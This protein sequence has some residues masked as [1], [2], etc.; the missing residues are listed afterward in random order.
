MTGR[1]VMTAGDVVAVLNALD[2]YQVEVSVAGGWAVDA[3]LGEQTREHAD[4]D[5]WAPATHLEWLLRALANRGLD[6]VFPCPGD[7]PWNFV[8][9]DGDRRRVDLHLYERLP[10]GRLHYGSAVDGTVFEAGALGGCGEIAG[11]RVRCEAP[12]WAVRWHT[13]YPP[14]AADRHDVP[15]LCAR[16][17]IPLPA[18]FS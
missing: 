11:R 8:L 3:L 18:D 14:R 10:D 7:R 1:Y 12:E 16:F 15:L 5:L 13:G 9:H 2:D 6:R 4:L 17:G